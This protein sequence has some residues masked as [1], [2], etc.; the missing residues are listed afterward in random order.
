MGQGD[1]DKVIFLIR[2]APGSTS[3]VATQRAIRATSAVPSRAVTVFFHG[4]AV[5][6]ARGPAA[7]WGGHHQSTAV[8]LLVC[9]AAWTRRFDDEPAAGFR[10]SSLVEF[11][12]HVLA[13]D[14]VGSVGDEAL[15][16]SCVLRIRDISSDRDA[17][18][19]LEIVLAGASLEID[20]DVLFEAEAVAFLGAKPARKWRQLVDHGLATIWYV[21]DVDAV[22][23]LQLAARPLDAKQIDDLIR[24]RILIDL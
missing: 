4:E 9:Q 24:G 17:T 6:A 19:M 8:Q 7:D 23:G 3:A 2:A 11:W 10:T 5:A 18:E 22:D 13:A 1:S 16:E 15:S 14:Q 20:L 12:T 21:G